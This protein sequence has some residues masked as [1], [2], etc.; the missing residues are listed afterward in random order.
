MPPRSNFNYRPKLKI[1]T[2][3]RAIRVIHC[4]LGSRKNRL[5]R[6]KAKTYIYSRRTC[7]TIPIHTHTYVLR[8]KWGTYTHPCAQ[9]K[10]LLYRRK[11]SRVIEAGGAA[12]TLLLSSGAIKI[13]R[14]P[15]APERPR[16]LRLFILFAYIYI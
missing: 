14:S 2:F 8:K 13:V 6:S 15:S 11:S 7:V 1:F 3:R 5:H 16:Q 12:V 9:K 4:A 10:S